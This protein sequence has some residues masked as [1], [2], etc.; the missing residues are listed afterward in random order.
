MYFWIWRED[1]PQRIQ[2]AVSGS[3]Q[4]CRTALVE[5]HCLK[6]L[7][8]REPRQTWECYR[9]LGFGDFASNWYQDIV[10]AP[11]CLDN[12]IRPERRKKHKRL[13]S[14]NDVSPRL[15]TVHNDRSRIF[16][17]PFSFWQLFEGGSNKCQCFVLGICAYCYY[18]RWP[19][20]VIDNPCH[21]FFATSSDKL[22]G[23]RRRSCLAPIYP[24]QIEGPNITRIFAN[25]AGNPDVYGRR[26]F[27]PRFKV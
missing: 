8:Y 1:A 3:S 13:F 18:C 10:S 6:S 25:L 11:H 14:E 26:T 24:E 4:Q 15:D 12:F 22:A 20:Q 21:L 23:N 16:S 19:L 17:V 2:T 7:F 9:V 27:K 5:T